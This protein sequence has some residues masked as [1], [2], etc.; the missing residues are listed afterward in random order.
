M[1]KTYLLLLTC[2][3]IILVS[4]N[5]T[6]SSTQPDGLVVKRI[7]PLHQSKSEYEKKINDKK[8]VQ[9]VYNKLLDLPPFSQSVVNCPIDNGV[10]YELTFINGAKTVSTA[11]VSAM[12][13]QDVT[14]KNKAYWGME[15]KG[16]GF[17][18]L[19]E[20]VL[21]LSESNFAVGFASK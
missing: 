15:P 5:G 17:R 6:A 20:H 19:L 18:V 12:G 21:D 11:M 7:D 4:C 16:K 14:M 1:K 9:E 2:L 8:M 10:Q 13:C 3:S